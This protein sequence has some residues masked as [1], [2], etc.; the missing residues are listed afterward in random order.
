MIVQERNIKDAVLK[1][2]VDGFEY[3]IFRSAS[4]ETLRHFDLIFIEYHFGVQDLEGKLVNAGF[5]VD[6][7]NIAN[8]VIDRHPAEYR[9]MDIGYILAKKVNV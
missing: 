7:K 5:S 6:K 4:N 9:N 3:E 8:M 2:D 1:L